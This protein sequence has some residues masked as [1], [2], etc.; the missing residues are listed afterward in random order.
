MVGKAGSVSTE[1]GVNLRTVQSGRRDVILYDPR[2]GLGPLELERRGQ[3]A[4]CHWQ[5]GCRC[6]M[7]GSGRPAPP[8]AMLDSNV[9]TKLL[10]VNEENCG[11]WNQRLER[12]P[13]AA[14]WLAVS[15]APSLSPVLSPP[16]RV[17]SDFPK[18]DVIKEKS[19]LT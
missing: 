7:K 6:V 4:L 2:N 15:S 14:G 13:S 16:R 1:G 19:Q 11:R 10:E 5:H 18:D 3:W 8:P 12:L 17:K 9:I